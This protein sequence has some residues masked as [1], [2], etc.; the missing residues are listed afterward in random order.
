MPLTDTAIR[1]A[2]PASR[3]QR[4]FDGGGMYLEIPP[5][6]GKWWRLKYRIDGK[7]KRMSLGTYP[8]TGL[9][10]ARARRDEARKLLAA[11]LDPSE[12]RKQAKQA[13]AATVAAAGVTFEAVAREWMS[14]QTVARVTAEKNRWLLETFLF[15]EIGSRPIV[16]IKPR[17]LLDALRKIE[18]TGK[19]ET[20][21]RAKIK[22]GQVF[23]HAMLEGKAE[24]DPTASLR[25]ALKVAKARHHAAVTEPVKIGQLLRAIEGFCGQPVTH[26]ALKLA[27]LVFVRPGE[28]RAAE[29]DEIDLDAAVWRIRPERMKMKSAHLVPLSS[30]AVAILRDLHAL[31]GGGLHVF[32]GLRPKRPMSEN[33]INAALRA[34]GYAGDEMTGHGFRSMAATRL[35]EMGWN[36]DAIERQL[37]HAE[38]NK[39]REAYTHAAQYLPER[40]RMMQAWADYLDGLRAGGNVVPLRAK[41]G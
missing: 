39:V 15:P 12:Q 10:A 11:G 21:S 4:L 7:E 17:E 27:P 3:T 1:K 35:N 20:A 8:D 34:L 24:I 41:A 31:T 9:A 25:G 38:T 30:Q 26:A 37:A 14:R 18:A 28:L 36:A 5:A 33:T 19:L 13:Q 6:G 23:R 29:W 22:A 40:V 16:E 32:P 2:K